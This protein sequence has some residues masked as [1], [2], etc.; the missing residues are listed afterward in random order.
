[1]IEYN[2]E[3][4]ENLDES[5]KELYEETDKG[6]QLK[7]TG[8]PAPENE[9]LT[10]LKNKVDELLREKKAVSLKAKEA[11]QEAEAAKLDAAKKG[12]DTEALDKSWREKFDARETE[13]NSELEKLSGTL[14]TL[15]S[16]QTASKI[17]AEIAVQGSA[18]VLLPHLE[19]RLKTEFRDGSPVTVVLDKDGKP[20]A[21]SMDELKSEFQNSAAFA[22]LIV[23]TKA[24]GAGRTGGNES[25][26]A[27]VN[28]I[29][30]SE[31]D[32]MNQVQRAKFAKSGGKLIND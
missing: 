12:N 17:A 27:G 18:D 1:M 15:T 13:L 32:R 6:Y 29:T 3:T 20:S 31:F 9:D 11:S 24:N 23:G 19:K 26:G 16:G 2:V 5:L 25:S 28:E 21:M 7:V 4:L 30:R 22:P 10:G 14:I 8:M